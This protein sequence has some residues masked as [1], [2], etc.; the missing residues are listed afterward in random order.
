MIYTYSLPSR[1]IC[2]SLMEA[3]LEGASRTRLPN[4]LRL[5]RLSHP[6]PERVAPLSHFLSSLIRRTVSRCPMDCA[7][8]IPLPCSSQTSTYHFGQLGASVVSSSLPLSGLAPPEILLSR[9]TSAHHCLAACE[10]D[11][12]CSIRCIGVVFDR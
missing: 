9:A 5:R 6:D 7:D 3:A 10:S 4:Q 12:P 11:V 1:S 2:S 8:G